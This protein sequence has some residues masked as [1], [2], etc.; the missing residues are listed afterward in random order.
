MFGRDFSGF[1]D[2]SY[3]NDVSI[4]NWNFQS[5]DANFL[6]ADFVW[7]LSGTADR[8]AP[9]KKLSP[10]E[11]KK[12]LN[13]WITPEIL[14]LIRVRDRLYARKKREPDNILVKRTFN[15]ARNRDIK[16]AK[17]SIINHIFNHTILILK[18]HGRVLEK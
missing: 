7:R 16:K 14:K 13:P 18:K 3:R 9:I 4:Q 12:R 6:M 17:K 15:R 10:K 11:V 2:E 1:S 8:H 5:N